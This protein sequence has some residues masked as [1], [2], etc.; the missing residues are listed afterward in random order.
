MKM[1]STL[2]ENN[3]KKRLKNIGRIGKQVLKKDGFG[4]SIV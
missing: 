2:H 1:D 4:I 3:G